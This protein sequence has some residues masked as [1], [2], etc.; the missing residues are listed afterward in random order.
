MSKN[1]FVQCTDCRVW[2]DIP[3][4][5][6]ESKHF[7]KCPKCNHA[8]YLLRGMEPKELALRESDKVV[9][10]LMLHGVNLEA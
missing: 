7:A 5:F 10:G 6:K 8:M 3:H 4:G 9:A 2:A 1:G